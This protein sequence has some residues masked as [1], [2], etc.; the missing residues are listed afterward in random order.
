MFHLK[1]ES[2]VYC[3]TLAHEIYEKSILINHAG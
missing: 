2:D 1:K 3:L